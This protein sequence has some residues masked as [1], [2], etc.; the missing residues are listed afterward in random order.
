MRRAVPLAC[1]AACLLAAGD[2]AAAACPTGVPWPAPDWAEAPLP[3]SPAMD[4]F[5]EYV[6]TLVGA[7]ADRIGRRTDAIVIVHRGRIIYERYG[8][9]YAARNRHLAWSVSKS[10]TSAL[11][12]AAVG[13]G[14]LTTEDSICDHYPLSAADRCEITVGDLLDWGSGFDWA[15]EYEGGSYYLSSVISMLYGVGWGDMAAFVAGHAFAHPPGTHY[16]YSTGDTVLLAAVL[17]GSLDEGLREGFPWDFLFDPIG[18]TSAIFERDHGGT[19]VGG[20]YV[21]ATPRDL[22]RFGYLYLRGGCW[23]G[24]RVLPE[25]WVEETTSPNPTFIGNPTDE[26]KMEHGAVPGRQ[27]WLNVELPELAHT[28]KWE[29]APADTFAA[30]GHWGQSIFVVPSRDLVIVRTADDREDDPPALDRSRYLE[31]ALALAAEDPP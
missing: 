7:D 4:A 1:L 30:L 20:S 27:W 3:A 28:S 14:Y 8:R 5:E 18:M 25:G 31:L 13:R 6:F 17:A 12:G 23:D 22:A 2:A 26:W 29:T 24:V 9:G 10:V 15:E 16:S 21:Y 11:V 19:F